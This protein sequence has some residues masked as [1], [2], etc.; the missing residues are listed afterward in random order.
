ML[1]P[2]IAAENRKTMDT[3]SLGEYYDEMTRFLP[4]IVHGGPDAPREDFMSDAMSLV[5]WLHVCSCIEVPFVS[6]FYVGSV[7]SLKYE[8]KA[9]KEWTRIAYEAINLHKKAKV[10]YGLRTDVSMNRASLHLGRSHPGMK[11]GV[12]RNDR[13]DVNESMHVIQYFSPNPDWIL[14]LVQLYDYPTLYHEFR[15]VNG[16]VSDGSFDEEARAFVT[17]ITERMKQVNIRPHHPQYLEHSFNGI[18]FKMTVTKNPVTGAWEV[19][20]AF[21]LDLEFGMQVNR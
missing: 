6:T 1:D 19:W 15:V 4:Q 9:L 11:R 10:F 3:A 7:K 13:F 5:S 16:E 8:Q 2:K 12:T 21:A 18:N 20:D 14:H 17:E